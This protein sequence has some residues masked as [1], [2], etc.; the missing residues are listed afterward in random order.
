MIAE[1]KKYSGNRKRDRILWNGL[2]FIIWSRLVFL[3]LVLMP[4]REARKCRQCANIRSKVAFK[5]VAT[6]VTWR[7]AQWIGRSRLLVFPKRRSS[8][9]PLERS[10]GTWF[11]PI[12]FQGAFRVPEV[13]PLP[14]CLPRRSLQRDPL[15]STLSGRRLTRARSGPWRRPNEEGPSSSSLRGDPNPFPSCLKGL[16]RVPGGPQPPTRLY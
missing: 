8:T 11:L 1:F 9:G 15:G 6:A 4:R 12:P 13:P 5:F 3:L 10:E 7:L 2:H 16:P 14:Q